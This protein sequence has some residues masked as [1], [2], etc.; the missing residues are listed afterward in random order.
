MDIQRMNEGCDLV[1]CDKSHEIFCKI[2]KFAEKSWK[3]A[4]HHMISCFPVPTYY[5]TNKKL[6]ISK[7][8]HVTMLV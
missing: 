1:S 6:E 8:G 3:E 4:Q 5:K 7:R 2:F